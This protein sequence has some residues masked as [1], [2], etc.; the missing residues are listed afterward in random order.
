MITPGGEVAFVKR[1]IEESVALGE[2]CRFVSTPS[3]RS[4]SRS[5]PAEFIL[6]FFSRWF[7]SLLGKSSSVG[8]I[9]QFLREK[10]VR[11]ASCLSPSVFPR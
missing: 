1:M 4:L 7:T 6:V 11:V 3:S 10:K 2:R 5:E 9:V 8:D